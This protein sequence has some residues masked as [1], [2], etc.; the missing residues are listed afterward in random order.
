[1]NDSLQT[2][3]NNT[4]LIKIEK[5]IMSLILG[6][7]MIARMGIATSFYIDTNK[8]EINYKNLSVKT[9]SVAIILGF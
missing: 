4:T 8:S 5:P 2:H 6:I 3:K 7:A 9:T 1:M